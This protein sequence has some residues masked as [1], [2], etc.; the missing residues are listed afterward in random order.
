MPDDTFDLPASA[1][2]FLDYLKSRGRKESTIRRYRYDLADFFRYID[3]VTGS[4]SFPASTD[5]QRIEGYFSLLEKNRHYQIRTLKRIQT[6]LKQYFSFLRGAGLLSYHPM[7]SLDLEESIW[8]EITSHDILHRLEEKKLKTSLLSDAGLSEKQ[9][10]A[11]PL[12]APRNLVIIRWFL[13]YGLRL[14]ELSCLQMEHLNEGRGLIHIPENTGNPRSIFLSRD[15]QSLLYHYLH[16]IPKAVRP[17]MKHHPIFAAFD[18][19]RQTYRWSYEQDRPKNLTEIA[20]QKMIREERKRA[21]I[22]R[23]VSAKHLR[24]TFIIRALQD[25]MSPKRLKEKLGLNS[26]LTLNKYIAYVHRNESR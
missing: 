19:Q 6:V 9:A 17:Y 23:A 16:G 11:R 7:A 8:D 12:L 25:G 15:D 26:I 2:T 18:F 1:E 3:V 14:Q 5:P 13:H 4:V 20:I 10:T 24:N 21:G 22:E